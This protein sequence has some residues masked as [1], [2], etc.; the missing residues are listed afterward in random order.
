[1]RLIFG[2][3]F[4]ENF[5]NFRLYKVKDIKLSRMLLK[6]SKVFGSFIV[7]RIKKELDI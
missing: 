3:F 1:M 2:G 6:V 5:V 7:L 4:L